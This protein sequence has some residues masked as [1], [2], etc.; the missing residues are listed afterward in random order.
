MAN[1]CYSHAHLLPAPCWLPLA[2]EA[3]VIYS[4]T[5]FMMYYVA[6]GDETK[7]LAEFAQRDRHHGAHLPPV[8]WVLA[9][10][11][12]GQEFW[13]KCKVRGWCVC[14]SVWQCVAVCVAVCVC[15]RVWLFACCAGR[16]ALPVI[17]AWMC[18]HVLLQMGVL[19]YVVVRLACTLLTF[20]LVFTK[21]YCNGALTDF[22]CGYIY[23]TFFVNCSQ[24]WYVQGWICGL[25][26][27]GSRLD[28]R[29][30]HPAHQGHVLLGTVLP[31]NVPRP[32]A[33][34]PVPQVP[35]HQGRRLL[36]V[37]AGGRH[38]RHGEAGVDPRHA[39][40]HHR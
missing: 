27:S 14:G 19:Q 1:R 34:A 17:H 3:Y 2:D 7:F 4:F 35:V 26:G 38:R 23:I 30:L 40:V 18:A 10:W 13:D 8:K 12:L 15:L 5:Y 9:Q 11:E 28:R 39:H 6:K 33:A 22:G 16:I 21:K 20:I 31:C 36:F 29:C 32:G 24:V 37:L 25:G